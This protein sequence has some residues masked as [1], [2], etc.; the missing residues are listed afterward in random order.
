MRWWV[1]VARCVVVAATV[2][3]ALG[4]CGSPS[5]KQDRETEAV[6]Q[7]SPLEILQASS[8][9]GGLLSSKVKLTTRGDRVELTPGSRSGETLIASASTAAS[10]TLYLTRPS[11]ESTWLAIRPLAVEATPGVVEQNAI[12]FAS[13]SEDADRALLFH[14]NRVEEFRVLRSPSAST[15]LTLELT[16]APGMAARAR[17][18]VVE[19]LGRDGRVAFRTLPAVAVDPAGKRRSLAV[20]LRSDAG[21]PTATWTLDPTGLDYPIVVDPAWVSGPGFPAQALTALNSIW[22]KDSGTTN[23]DVAVID[24]SPGPV[25]ADDAETVVGQHVTL[26]G[27]LQSN[28]VRIKVGG[29]ITGDVSTND[30]VN[31]GTIAGS[32]I[33]PLI[34][35]LG[36]TTPAI[37]TITPST[38]AITLEQSEDL[39]LPAGAYG[40]VKLKAGMNADRTV[41]SLSGTYHFQSL[42]L[43]DKSR[44]ECTAPCSI[45][46]KDRLEPGQDAFLGPSTGSGLDASN[47]EVIVTGINGASGNLGGTPRAAAIG[48]D[49][50]VVARIFVPNGTL[51]LKQGTNATGTFVARDLLIGE[52]VQITK[53]IPQACNPDDNN[54]CTQD[55]CDPIT[56]LPVH[57]P[58]PAGTS[59]SNGNACDGAEAC[60]GLGACTP[61]TPPSTDDGN[62]CTT[63]SCDPIAGVSHT[64]DPG[65][66]CEDGDACTSSDTCDAA[67]TCQPGTPV[68]VDDGEVCT[69]DT[70][71]SVTGVSHTPTP[72]AACDDA[73]ACTTGDSCDATGTCQPGAPVSTDDGNDCTSD[74]CDPVAGITHTPVPGASCDD[75]DQCTAGDTCD[76]AASCVP[77]APVAVDDSNECT[78]DACDPVAGVTHTPNPG[79]ACDDGNVCSSGD[80]CDATGTCQ[81][82]TPVST[83]DG[84][85]CTTDSCDPVA[86]IT[87]TPAPGA[88]CDDGDQCTAGDTCDA[89]ASCVPG[90][91][92]TVDDSNECTIDACDPTTGV[93]HTPNTGASCSDND[94]CTTGDTCSAAGVCQPGAPVPSDDGNPCTVDLC[95]TTTGDITHPPQAIGVPCTL[96]LCTTGATCDGAGTCAGGTP[97]IRRR[98]RSL[99]HRHLQPRD[100]PRPLWLLRSRPHRLHDDPRLDELALHRTECSAARRAAGNHR[101]EA[102]SGDSRPGARPSRSAH[103]RSLHHG[104]RSSRARFHDHPRR[105]NVRHGG[106][107][108]R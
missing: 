79:A 18:G 63:D 39:T 44:V 11:D 45:L 76:A 53:D 22:L 98:R 32:T 86:G 20:A 59:C 57:D 21:V 89:A 108:R 94:A 37:P 107:R 27:S 13:A 2:P 36:I 15:A 3:L 92:V 100:R 29:Q 40:D 102:S 4:A 104:A 83:D 7:T 84:D 97:G 51:W 77:G 101:R 62:A 87:H 85:D 26:N 91:P 47:V 73:N 48:F 8:H 82:G 35:P 28:R 24:I 9:F 95:D 66:A 65:A 34:L 103:S 61:G 33:S 12:V 38:T 6:R 23:G 105:R 56:G 31:N 14:L 99:H 1:G 46:V 88:P 90:T 52:H 70:C 5:E 17:S 67:G 58:L 41:L 69:T 81:P 64:P 50:E 16:V 60:D 43:G 71:D 80:A 25:L 74:A 68:Q 30:L 106:E 78:I 10:G 54:A 96:D 93:S 75:G 72:G 55:S 42:N 49:N 19:V